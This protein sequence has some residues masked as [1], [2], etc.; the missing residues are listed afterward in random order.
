MRSGF[1]LKNI[2]AMFFDRQKILNKYQ[3]KRLRI[4][5]RAGAYVLRVYKSLIKNRDSVSEPGN[6]PSGHPEN[7]QKDG[8]LEQY[9]YFVYDPQSESVLVGPAKLNKVYFDGNGQPLTG[10]VTE[11][12]DRGGDF[13]IL[14]VFKRGRWQRADL[15][16][17]RR[18]AGLPTRL[19][20][21]HIAARPAIGPALEKSTP[22]LSEFWRDAIS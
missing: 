22:K 16:S 12:L 21:V 7:G 15:R 5:S 14:E 19:R 18:I 4:L 2:T 6:P 10:T 9:S 11:I 13:Q 1:K 3:A 17:R 20:R 8:A